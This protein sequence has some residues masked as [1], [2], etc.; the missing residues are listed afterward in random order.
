MSFKKSI[1]EILRE[2]RKKDSARESMLKWSREATRLSSQAVALIHRGRL[3]E[4]RKKLEKARK[5]LDK[6]EEAVRNWPELANSGSLITAY[7]EYVEAY[8]LYSTLSNQPIPGLAE[9]QVPPAAYLLGLA[10][11]IGELRREVLERI[12][13]GSLEEA[14]KLLA[15]MEEVYTEL[16]K[17]DVSDAL[18]PGLRRKCDV[19]RK[20]I[21]TTAG[22]VALEVRR[23][24]LENAIRNLEHG[25]GGAKNRRHG[26]ASI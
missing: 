14:Q 9:L 22:D 25:L 5:H 15:L 12:K 1:S 21:E 19:A 26:N 23:Q 16:I 6:A 7:Q 24:S 3:S 17:V 10:D 13:V 18:T 4:A 20:L 2:L 8:A 11:F